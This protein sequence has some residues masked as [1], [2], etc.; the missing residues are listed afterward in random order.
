MVRVIGRM[1]TLL[2]LAAPLWL[3]GLMAWAVYETA[4]FNFPGQ[5]DVISMAW[6]LSPGLVIGA[7]AAMY[8]R[9]IVSKSM[10]RMACLGWTLVGI[11]AVYRQYEIWGGVVE[12]GF[13]N[14]MYYQHQWTIGAWFAT[15]VALTGGGIVWRLTVHGIGKG[16]RFE[17]Q[18]DPSKK[19]LASAQWANPRELAADMKPSD[20]KAEVILAEACD[21]V[22][23]P[24]KVGSSPLITYDGEQSALVVAPPGSGK[25]TALALPNLITF[26]GPVIVNDTKLELFAAT[27][28]RRTR[29]GYRPLLFTDRTQ[30]TASVDVLAD[31]DPASERFGADFDAILEAMKSGHKA[32]GENEDFK[33]WGLDLVKCLGLDM[34]A[35]PARPR[36][37]KTLADLAVIVKS[38]N[39]VERLQAIQTKTEEAEANGTL[40]AHGIPGMLA[41]T[42]LTI[43]EAEKQWAGVVSNASNLVTWLTNPALARVVS[44]R[45]E[46]TMRMSRPS[47][48]LD[49]K[50]DVFMGF[51]PSIMQMTPQV[52]R[53]L[54]AAFA[55]AILRRTEDA[56]IAAAGIDP[57]AAS[58]SRIPKRVLYLLDE[59][60][61]LGN[62]PILERVRDIG[63]GA[64]MSIMMILQTMAQ[65]EDI[66]GREGA[67]KWLGAL[68]VKLFFGLSDADSAEY[69]SKMIGEAEVT[70]RNV[71]RNVGGSRKGVEWVGTSSD[72]KS[73]SEQVQAR[74]LLAIEEALKLPK[75]TA[76]LLI[77]G[78][79]PCRCSLAYVFRRAEWKG[80]YKEIKT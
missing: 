22:L 27:R 35:D 39:L 21:P 32:G 67:K 51:P 65:L 74:R 62:M 24:K 73:E 47:E 52:G 37:R 40:Y 6:M 3:P 69:V 41:G 16:P 61:Q 79:D 72:G 30:M 46:P 55:N 68:P 11:R 26:D 8:R 15:V 59:A 2:L 78:K 64:G 42:L 49:C 75:G 44:G 60:A 66:Y 9:E 80:L 23:E 57:N 4:A 76:I 48:F 36:E 54:T 43:S 18:V 53:V 19:K 71:S 28:E 17:S 1:V 38:T 58:V 56:S 29:L 50:T 70:T 45:G 12:M 25:T 5:Y 31:I 77:S 13:A 7:F 63:R 34:L 20:G 14:F 10:L 33:Q